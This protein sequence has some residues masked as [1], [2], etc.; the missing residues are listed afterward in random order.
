M[1]AEHPGTRAARFRAMHEA[2]FLLPNAWD[3]ASA[4]LF[5]G[6]APAIATSSAAAA[7]I[8][9]LRD[10]ERIG[11][12]GALSAASAIIAAADPT[13]VNVDLEAGFGDTPEAVADVA[14]EAV[15]LGAAG[16]NLEDTDPA[17]RELRDVGL[18]AE[19]VAA[20]AETIARHDPDVVLNARTD[21]FWNG[22]GDPGDRP[23]DAR[24]RLAAYLAAGA[25]CLFVP[26][27][28]P[29]SPEALAEAVG[30]PA[31]APVNLLAS[32]SAGLGTAELA[33]AGVRRI[34]FGSSLYRAALAHAS[35]LVTAVAES[36]A[37]GALRSADALSY[38]R[39]AEVV[40]PGEH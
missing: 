4:R 20:S 37:F 35:G 13:P 11:R 25:T 38:R 22:V 6:Q 33:A 23:A 39:L 5:A 2:L 3:A 14:G 28:V 32:A 21:V 16:V 17:T 10:G 9:G 27:L 24:T 31:P 30:A 36:G 18:Q 12:S 19:I 29:T 34:S 7:A 26:G 8:L 15:G 1:N 40:A